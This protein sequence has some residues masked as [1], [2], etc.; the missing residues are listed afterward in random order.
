[1]LINSTIGFRKSLFR[2]ISVYLDIIT[3]S[4]SVNMFLIAVFIYKFKGVPLITYIFKGTDPL[5]LKYSVLPVKV[6]YHYKE[7]IK[8]TLKTLVK[9][10]AVKVNGRIYYKYISRDP[11]EKYA[12]KSII[13]RLENQIEI[14]SYSTLLKK[15]SSSIAN[16]YRFKAPSYKVML[17]Y[18]EQAYYYVVFK[19]PNYSVVKLDGYYRTFKYCNFKISEDRFCK[20]YNVYPIV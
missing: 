3:F 9:Y 6:S 20:V 16:D 11:L 5:N 19:S 2:V 15:L 7:N 13:W 10:K 12:F 1:M 17:G 8:N 14:E 18:G 4:D